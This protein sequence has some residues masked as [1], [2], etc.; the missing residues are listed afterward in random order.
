MIDHKIKPLPVNTTIREMRRG[1]PQL[2]CPCQIASFSTS[3][4]YGSKICKTY[5][6]QYSN[7]NKIASI[8]H[9]EHSSII[10]IRQKI[11]E[12]FLYYSSRT[13]GAKFLDGIQ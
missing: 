5:S 4:N 13:N 9:K 1:I 3:K 8:N 10:H 12:K 7:A 6:P 2:V 11:P